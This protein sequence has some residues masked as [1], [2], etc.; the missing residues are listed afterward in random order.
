M[1]NTARTSAL[2]AALALLLVPVAQARSDNPVCATMGA[3]ALAPPDWF[4]ALCREPFAEF[5]PPAAG[6]WRVPG[7]TAIYLANFSTNAALNRRLLSAPLPTVNYTNIAPC[8]ANPLNIFAWDFDL[9]ANTLWAIDSACS[10]G[11]C[12]GRDLGTVNLTT[13]VFTPT[14][15]ITGPPAGTNFSGLKFDPTSSNVYISVIAGGAS[16]LWTLNL[17]TGVATQIGGTITGFVIDIAIDNTGQMY[18]HEIINDVFLRI[19]KATGVATPVG[20]TNAAANFAQGMDFDPS[21]NT[22]YAFV[23]SSVGVSNISTVNLTTGAFTPVV[24]NGEELEGAIQLPAL[25]ISGTALAVDAAGNGVLEAGETA[26][27]AP[28]WM[29]ESSLL[30]PNVTGTLS[31]FTGPGGG[32]YTID[33]ASATYGDIAAGATATCTTDCYGVTVTGTPRPAQHWDTTADEALS[34]PGQT[35]TWTLHVGGSFTDVST[36]SAFYR[37]IETLLH[38]GV[39]GGCTATDYCPTASTTREQMA[40]FVLVAKEGAGY[41]PVACAPPN[42]FGDVPDT[43]PFCRF[44]EELANRQVVTGCGPNL[45]CPSAEVTREQMAIFALRTLDPALDPPACVAG[46]EMFT[47]VPSTSPFCRWVEELARRGVV[48]G[49]GPNLYCPSDPVTREQMGVFLSVTFG[50]T[51]YGA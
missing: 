44:I 26:V 8:G 29:N 27:V 1:R 34:V 20:P 43:S 28:S 30:V 14:V 41:T 16:S 47:D 18:G 6:P 12:T 35:H 48:S 32:T 36:A 50:L 5:E 3:S 22:L 7:D 40:V 17:Q 24:A 31:N 38:Q 10:T 45:Y 46:S 49:C 23:I 15:Q 51:L 33:D 9:A 39:T 19:D 21:D 11:T 13:G 4:M 42:L 25:R 37:F 2:L